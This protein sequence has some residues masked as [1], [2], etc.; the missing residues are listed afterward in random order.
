MPTL[1]GT[2]PLS[3]EQMADLRDN[4]M[5]MQLVLSGAF[6]D[7]IKE[8]KQ[9]QSDI[10]VKQEALI[11][12]DEANSVRAVADKYAA[13]VK[14]QSDELFERANQTLA[15]TDNRAGE[16]ARQQKAIDAA[17]I[18]LKAKQADFA[19][20]QKADQESLQKDR[21]SASAAIKKAN[22]DLVNREAVLEESQKQ[23][24]EA[25]TELINERADI[26]VLK[27]Q[28]TSKLEAFAKVEKQ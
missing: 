19:V 14:A 22:D 16:I 9:I 2:P 27:A 1:S 3:A 13:T 4:A 18:D 5:A 25:Q 11:A 10:T 26:A 21:D 6:D 28:L 15:A 23:L 24:V 8:L 12:L 7:R 20:R 17:L